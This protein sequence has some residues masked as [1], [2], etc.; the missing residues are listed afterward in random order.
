[1]KQGG[2]WSNRKGD[3][4][5]QGDRIKSK[6][7]REAAS[8]IAKNTITAWG[9]EEKKKKRGKNKEEDNECLYTESSVVLEVGTGGFISL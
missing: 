6:N 1:M 4:R 2:E 8:E 9:D 5:D 7:Q 3:W